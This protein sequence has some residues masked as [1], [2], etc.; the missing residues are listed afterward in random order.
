MKLILLICILAIFLLFKT[1][2]TN[3]GFAQANFSIQSSNL[4]CEYRNKHPLFKKIDKLN[5]DLN[6]SRVLGRRTSY[7]SKIPSIETINSILSKLKFQK[8]SIEYENLTH[9]V[10]T[11]Y[12]YSGEIIDSKKI[13]RAIKYVAN[14]IILGISNEINNNLET[15]KCIKKDFCKPKLISSSL[16]KMQHYNK[17]QFKY[18]LEFEIFIKNKDHSYIFYS[19][20][21]EINGKYYLNTTKYIGRRMS[22]SIQLQKPYDKNDKNI[23]IYNNLLDSKYN[24]SN[25]YYR[26]SDEQKKIILDDKANIKLVKKQKYDLEH[27]NDYRC[28]GKYAVNKKMCESKTDEFMKPDIKGVWDRECRKDSECPFFKSNK[29]YDNNRGGCINGTCEMPIGIVGKGKRYYFKNSVPR[30][31]NCNSDTSVCCSEQ[32]DKNLYP[33]LITPDYAFSNDFLDRFDQKNNFRNK[34]LRV[35]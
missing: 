28:Y 24:V 21:E 30:C 25:D 35:I 10:H 14:K 7:Y 1:K 15:Y 4:K 9:P 34:N 2:Y 12:K 18:F 27:Q 26:N 29:N 23:N 13:S 32:N 16:I 22:D 31:Y 33:N 6:H 17:K 5:P 3:E 11:I 20:I 8:S 19:E